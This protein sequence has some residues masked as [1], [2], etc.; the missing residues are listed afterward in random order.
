MHSIFV[1]SNRR[2]PAFMTTYFVIQDHTHVSMCVCS[3]I[4]Q[5]LFTI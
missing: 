3:Y 5:A 4:N 2:L 1:K